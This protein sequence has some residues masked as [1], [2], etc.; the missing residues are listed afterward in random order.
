MIDRLQQRFGAFSVY[1]H[2]RVLVLLALGFSSGLPLML[3]FG[4]LSFWLREAGIDRTTI[5]FLSWVAM[6]YTVKFLWAPV[7]DRM[8]LP[9]ATRLFGRRRS[10]MLLSQLGL[11]LG[12]V[13]MASSDPTQNLTA[14]VGFALM[15]A[16]CSATQDIVI[17][18]FR[19]ETAPE[20]MQGALAAA[21]QTGYR[22]GMM[23]ATAGALAI[24]AWAGGD[25]GYNPVGWQTAYLAMAAAMSVGIIATLLAKEPQINPQRLQLESLD[26]LE[27]LLHLPPRLQRLLMWGYT[28]VVCPFKD[29]F[30]R[31][32]RQA[33]L[34]LLLIA[35]YRIS[36]VVM[37]VMANVF[38][39]D[40]GFSKAEIATISKVYG[41]IMT[42]V[43]AAVGGV[44]I[45][46][47]GTLKILFAGA[48]AVALTNLLFSLQALVG[49]NTTLLTVVI[50]ADS[51]SA[52]IATA[53]FI[54]YLSSLTNVAFS[55][56]QYALLSSMMLLLPKFL[57]GFSGAL[58]DAVGYPSFF[59]LCCLLG[60]P[61]LVL[62]ALT[63][64]HGSTDPA[65]E[66]DAP[67][68]Q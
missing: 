59:L 64:R 47:F 5:G 57:A 56:T 26:T 29:F 4:S 14:L 28:A 46:R 42:M 23:L 17:D 33:L 31:F 9:L 36:D 40:M 12:L 13:G 34:I 19:I 49:Y 61:V 10:W 25:D 68:Q 45:A 43:G 67:Q 7:V 1:L 38:Y 8:P 30:Q 66:A 53:A 50:A 58:V 20:E 32:G 44:L 62:I 54:T 48:L 35:C 37:G 22:L 24:A 52:G 18:A 65:P 41:V 60:L 16:L 27:R 55:A 11:V 21:Y 6:A 39:V 15:V 63:A 3:V 2:K 51:F